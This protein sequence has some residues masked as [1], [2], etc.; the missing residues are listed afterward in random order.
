MAI[1]NSYVS[2]YQRVLFWWFSSSMNWKISFL[3]QDWTEAGGWVE[4]T[5]LFINLDTPT[6]YASLVTPYKPTY[7]QE[8]QGDWDGKWGN[9]LAQETRQLEMIEWQATNLL[10]QFAKKSKYGGFHSHGGILQKD[11]LFHGKSSSISWMITRATPMT[12]WKP[13]SYWC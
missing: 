11:G 6:I 9:N 13:L 7:L 10:M 1:F 4:R 5:L 12:K 2:H 3:S 8:K